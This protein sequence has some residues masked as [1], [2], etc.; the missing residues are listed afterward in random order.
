M[1]PLVQGRVVDKEARL[2]GDQA[3]GQGHEVV[4]GEDGAGVA[5]HGG[6][7]PRHGAAAVAAVGEGAVLQAV[8]LQEPKWPELGTFGIFEFFQ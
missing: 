8:A 7:V 6:G 3:A 2:E 5:G 1:N 4:H